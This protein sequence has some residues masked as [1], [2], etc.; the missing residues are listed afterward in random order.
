MQCRLERYAKF[1]G[2]WACA[3]PQKDPVAWEFH[4]RSASFSGLIGQERT[5]HLA[6]AAALSLGP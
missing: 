1:F 2:Y 5:G 6:L 4:Y 3:L